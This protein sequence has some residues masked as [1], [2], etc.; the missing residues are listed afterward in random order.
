MDDKEIVSAVLAHLADK[1]GQ[2]RF[3]LWFGSN[4]RL[5]VND[6]ALMVAAGNRFFQDWLRQNFRADI[7]AACQA[8]IG[9]R[10]S[11]EFRI[12]AAL[13]KATA[14]T[15]TSLNGE[16]AKSPR[17]GAAHSHDRNHRAVAPLEN[18]KPSGVGLL[19]PS[20]KLACISEADVHNT[21]A[22]AGPVNTP[23]LGKATPVAIAGN[24]RRKFARLDTFCVGSSNKVAHA[25]AELVAE[26][27]GS[28]NPLFLHG[29]TGVGKTHLLEGIWSAARH[30][31]ARCHVVYRTAEQFTTDFLEALRGSGLPSFRRKYRGLDVL[32]LDDVQFFAGKRATLVELLHTMDTLM[33]EGRQIVLA[34]DRSVG[35][36]NELGHELSARLSAGMVARMDAPDHATRIAIVRRRAGALG[37][38]LTADVEEFIATHLTTHARELCGAINRLHATSRILN[39]PITRSLAEEALAE[40]IQQTGRAVHLDDIEKAV[41]EVFGL[42]QD[43]LQSA[44]R[45]KSLSTARML[46]MWLARKHTRAALS[47]IGQHFGRR[48]H[49]TV[50]SAQKTVGDWVTKQS[51]VDLANK[52]CSVEDAIRKVEAR[53]RTG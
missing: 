2:D 14:P 46:A 15:N 20:I 19:E 35:D 4:V 38:T 27:A 49:S 37:L 48:S 8:V 31:N 6:T 53:L 42:S 34:A 10:L 22:Q 39:Q 13:L 12:D 16:K 1:V 5:T 24:E 26:R 32:I 11:I 43:S 18:A 40:M 30:R 7:E 45:A 25:S 9:S 41:C 47:E 28:M 50:I 51:A 3:E 21:P 29:P 44:R 36:L 52:S 17:S 33:R 23:Q